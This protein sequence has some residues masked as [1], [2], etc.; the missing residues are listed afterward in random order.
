MKSDIARMIQ[1]LDLSEA[2]EGEGILLATLLQL[3]SVVDACV[4]KNNEL[5]D[6]ARRVSDARRYSE[7][8][9]VWCRNTRDTHFNTH[10][11]NCLFELA[12]RLAGPKPL[13]WATEGEA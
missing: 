5:V 7:G 3:A 12:S 8:R 9:C 2:T 10:D 4:A 11:K 13:R 1:D 6:F